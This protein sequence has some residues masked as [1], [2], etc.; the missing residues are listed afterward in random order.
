MK[1]IMIARAAHLNFYTDVLREI[2]APVDR[3]LQLAGLPTI[4]D[5]QPNAYISAHLAIKFLQK[6]EPM[7]GLSDL[8]FL[9][10]Q[11][12]T[13]ADLS[14]AYRKAARTIPSL[15][16]RLK[17][18]WRLAYLEDNRI[19]FWPVREGGS[20]RICSSIMGPTGVESLRFSEWLQHMGMIAVVRQF[21]GPKWTPTSIAFRSRFAPDPGAF[22]AFPNTRF[23]V[24]QQAA[25]VEV[26]VGLLSLPLRSH[27]GDRDVSGAG[28]S[29]SA[30]L[31]D[32]VP[33]FTRSLKLALRAYLRD[34]H[35]SVHLA[36]E[37]AG[38]SVRTLQRGFEESG[39]TYS[40]LVQQVRFEAAAELLEDPGTKIIDIALEVGFEDP[41]HFAR[42]FRKISGVTPREYR[43][44]LATQ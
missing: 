4:L 32:P 15:Y 28:L 40:D 11:H 9:A 37:I 18:L 24:G 16:G 3:E 42:A 19:R 25:H 23:L 14:P 43:Q 13:V 34:G 26:P 6:M 22:E 2:G 5:D 20:M 7:E 10:S 30:V 39:L 44:S 21:A 8:A 33:D 35:P 38:T 17:L 29:A 1:P 41:S 36:A 12:L 31:A 27:Q